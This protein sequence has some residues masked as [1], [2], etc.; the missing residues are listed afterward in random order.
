MATVYTKS[1]AQFIT[2]IAPHVVADMKKNGVLASVTIAQAILES[3]YGNTDLAR[4]ANNLFGMKRVLSG[5]AWAGSTWDGVSVYTKQ[6]PEDDGKGNIYY[7]T[8]DFRAYP[9]VAESVGDHS[10]YLL[11]A[12]NGSKKRYAGLQG[13]KDP[14]TAITIIKNGGYATDT[15]YIDKIM[16]LITE[17]DLTAYDKQTAAAESNTESEA[18]KMAITLVDK[19]MKNSPCYKAGTKIKV[20]GMYIHSIGCPCEKAQNIINNENQSGANA[21]VQAV[22]QHDG[23][24]LQGLPVYPENGTAIRNWHCGSG[25]NG[26]GNNTHIGIEMCEP[27]TIKYTSG[28]G[29][30]ELGDGSNTKAVVLANYKHAVE[31]FALRCQQ[32]GL[33][34]MK[35]G[36]IISHKE[37]HAR[38]LA[39]NHGDPEH[40]WGKFG[41]SPAGF[42]KD[43]AAKMA[44]GKISV[45][46]TPAVTDDG[47]QKIN[48]LAGTVT[49]IYEGTHGVNDGINIRKTPAFTDN[50]A[51]VVYTGATF[52]VNGISADEKFYQID[53]G[54]SRRYIT[55]VPEYVKF[56][57][58]PEQ[59]ESTA[60]TGYYRVRKKWEDSKTQIGAFKQLQNAVNACL[61]NV[62]YKVFDND[63]KQIYPAVTPAATFPYTVRVEVD[64]LRIRKGAGTTYDY[65]K[66][67][68]KPKYTGKGTFTIVAEKNGAG[69]SKWGLLKAYADGKDGWISL[70]FC[71]KVK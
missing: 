30:V 16:K 42:R 29:W 37:G 41:L 17:N 70:D 11:G 25:S 9:S 19:T 22:I 36:V 69:A 26:S 54:G 61:A 57:A 67:N 15:Q 1:K 60:G 4:N 48:P 10:A 12:M 53:D 45:D 46:G 65:H 51:R 13:E 3:G 58:T 14:R 39:S 5:N 18:Q 20:Q 6:T 33:D 2:E 7:I 68:G 49:V 27:A 40:I 38:G 28:S 59:K 56:K 35:D 32:F 43:V 63:G 64:D 31:Y 62:G 24:V 47:A 66:E 52:T 55:A 21:A 34:P 44:G 8:A 50:V 23:Q 71:T